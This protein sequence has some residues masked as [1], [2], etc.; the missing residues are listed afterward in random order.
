[1]FDRGV[2]REFPNMYGIRFRL[3]RRSTLRYEINNP[4]P[5]VQIARLLFV[6][7]AAIDRGR[8]RGGGNFRNR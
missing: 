3:R 6:Y 1:M 4:Q 8:K 7:D 5:T 2:K